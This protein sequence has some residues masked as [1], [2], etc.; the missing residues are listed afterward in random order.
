[1]LSAAVQQ[2]VF[3]TDLSGRISF[4]NPAWEKLSGELAEQS[5]GQPWISLIHPE[6]REPLHAAF[7]D[8]MTRRTRHVQ[9]DARLAGPGPAPL[10]VSVYLMTLTDEQG[11]RA[12]GAIGTLFDINE[13]KINES[14]IRH[15]ALHDA[16]TGVPNRLLLIERLEQA[17]GRLR[18]QGS[19]LAVLYVDLDDFKLVNDHHG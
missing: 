3:E 18:R 10:W 1:Q 4:I 19:Q 13:R 7:V 17:L 12:R 14:A 16:L 6:D 8:L 5:I 9:R 11:G 2:V 15:Q